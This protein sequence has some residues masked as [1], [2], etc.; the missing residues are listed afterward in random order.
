MKTITV[1]IDTRKSKLVEKLVELEREKG[2]KPSKIGQIVAKK[3]RTNN[4]KSEA[5][6]YSSFRRGKRRISESRLPILA[7]LLGTT[8]QVLREINETFEQQISLEFD[9]KLKI[10]RLL[11]PFPKD[12]EH[13]DELLVWLSTENS[14]RQM[15]SQ[16]AP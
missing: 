12:I 11:E 2:L 8:E 14:R 3:L 16:I 7:E 5:T 4:P 10:R 9:A 13:L 6:I 15:F 1:I